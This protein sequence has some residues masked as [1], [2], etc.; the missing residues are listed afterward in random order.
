MDKDKAA[1]LQGTLDLPAIKTV[2]AGGEQMK[3][4]INRI[5]GSTR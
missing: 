5:L 3:A 4:F 2:A 1:I